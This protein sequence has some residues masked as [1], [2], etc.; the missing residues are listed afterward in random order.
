VTWRASFLAFPVLLLCS[1]PRAAW[2]IDPLED[3]PADEPSFTFSLERPSTP[4]LTAEAYT[5]L[6][7]LRTRVAFWAHAV[8]GGQVRLR[9]GLL[10]VGGF[11]ERSDH[12]EQGEFR[13]AGAFAGVALPYRNWVDLHGAV[14][15]GKRTHHEE[16]ERYGPSGYAVSS[17]VLGL[18]AGI[19]DRS[20]SGTVGVRLGFELR[21]DVDWR[22]HRVPW[23]VEYP[24]AGAEPIVFSGVTDAGGMTTAM[25]VTVGLDV[26]AGG[27]PNTVAAKTSGPL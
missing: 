20:G 13:A 1:L 16:D 14:S 17:P 24:V 21:V 26:A 2:A 5:G 18:R 10:E 22:R 6:S 4:A 7:V 19:S 23:R 25:V 8:G 15:F 27:A 12:Q 3:L 9:L 11:Y